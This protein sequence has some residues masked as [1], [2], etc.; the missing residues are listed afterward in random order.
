MTSS[1]IKFWLFSGATESSA[2]SR[3]NSAK[4]STYQRRVISELSETNGRKKRVDAS[5]QDPL[6]PAVERPKTGARRPTEDEFD[7]IEVDDNLLPD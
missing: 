7:D 5:Y 2:G 4:K 3:N 1:C 6:G